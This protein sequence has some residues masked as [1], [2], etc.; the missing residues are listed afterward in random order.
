M[1]FTPVS[2]SQL[3]EADTIIRPKDAGIRMGIHAGGHEQAARTLQKCSSIRSVIHRRNRKVRAL[4]KDSDCFRFI[5]DFAVAV[6]Y[7]FLAI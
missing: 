4:S 5:I 1:P 2:A 3:R 7:L 6:I